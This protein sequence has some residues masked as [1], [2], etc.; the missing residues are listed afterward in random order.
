MPGNFDLA[1]VCAL[2]IEAALA[3]LGVTEKGL[4]ENQVLER[5]ATYGLN[6]IAKRRK[7]GFVGE[8]LQRCK[9]PLVIQLFVIAL[10]S[11]A[12]SDLRAAI[13]VGVMIILSVF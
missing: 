9:N 2:T 8:I 7:L 1:A 3:Q 11:F 12:M 5:R 4:P 10:V 6:E 13:V